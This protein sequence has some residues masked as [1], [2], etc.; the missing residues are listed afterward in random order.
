MVIGWL[1]GRA[2]LLARC[3]LH[4]PCA[5]SASGFAPKRVSPYRRKRGPRQSRS[6]FKGRIQFDSTGGSDFDV[7]SKPLIMPSKEIKKEAIHSILE[8]SPL[9]ALHY[10]G[11]QK[12]T[13]MPR[14]ALGL[15]LQLNKGNF[16]KLRSFI[17]R[18]SKFGQAHGTPVARSSSIFRHI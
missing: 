13:I 16:L 3:A 15:L 8:Q 12:I 4:N 17:F 6:K 7:P 2:P 18:K 14:S 5:S 1:P 9:D 10:P 11:I